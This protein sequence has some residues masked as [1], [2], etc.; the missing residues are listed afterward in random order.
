MAVYIKII[1]IIVSARFWGALENKIVLWQSSDFGETL[2][3]NRTINKNKHFSYN[4]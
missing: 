4:V 1:H 3:G 2:R